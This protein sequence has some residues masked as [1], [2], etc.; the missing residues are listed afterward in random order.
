MQ[1]TKDVG[2]RAEEHFHFADGNDRLHKFI[3]AEN[4]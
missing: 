1:R 3:A 4:R 2:T